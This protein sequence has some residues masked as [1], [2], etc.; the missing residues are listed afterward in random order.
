[1]LW[2]KRREAEEGKVQASSA[3][4]SSFKFY[5]P[6]GGRPR[7]EDEFTDLPVSSTTKWRYRMRKQGRCMKCGRPRPCN[8]HTAKAIA[9]RAQFK[10]WIAAG[11]P[12]KRDAA[13]M[14]TLQQ[15]AQQFKTRAARGPQGV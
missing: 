10:A 4:K 3:P 8:R 13:V 1:M 5:G 9:R 6:N 15:S 14:Q 2:W 12:K 11:R 7:I